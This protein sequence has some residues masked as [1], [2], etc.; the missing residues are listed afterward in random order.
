M[1]RWVWNISREG[2]STASLGSLG[3]GS[4]TLRGKKFFLGFSWT[5]LCS[6]LCPLPLEVCSEAEEQ[7]CEVKGYDSTCTKPCS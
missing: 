1:S 7:R 5:F 2:D 4:G 3:Q 6:S